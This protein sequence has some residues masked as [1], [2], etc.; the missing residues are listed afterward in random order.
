MYNSYEHSSVKR[1]DTVPT[2]TRRVRAVTA[3]RKSQTA[4]SPLLKTIGASAAHPAAAHHERAAPVRADGS[5]GDW[6]ADRRVNEN[7]IIYFVVPYTRR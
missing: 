5:L 3:R 1:T 2:K 6:P 4:L 7:V